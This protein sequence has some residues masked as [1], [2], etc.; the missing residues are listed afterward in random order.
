MHNIGC[1]RNPSVLLPLSLVDGPS[2]DHAVD[3][4]RMVEG[5]SLD[6]VPASIMTDGM[7]AS[8]AQ[9]RHEGKQ[10]SSHLPL[11][12]LRV[13][14]AVR[15]CRRVPIAAQVGTDD[16][17]TRLDQGWSDC[18]PGG[19][20][21]RVTVHQEYCRAVACVADPH[22]HFADVQVVEPKVVKHVDIVGST[23]GQRGYNPIAKPQLK[24]YLTRSTSLVVPRDLN[25]YRTVVFGCGVLSP[26]TCA[27]EN[28]I[29][30]YQTVPGLP[31][32]NLTVATPPDW[33][34]ALVALAQ[35]ALNTPL[36]DA[37]RKGRLVSLENW[38]IGTV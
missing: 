29:L 6:D 9:H 23:G 8:M 22:A 30:M 32:L 2:D 5:E 4:P 27:V 37:F 12:R 38:V 15:G 14:R 35:V 25:R 7:E 18:I 11:A 28:R 33:V 10:I 13:I 21:T 19:M 36:P 1:I 16:A 31:P 3:A 34:I 20:G 26:M 17:E 24:R